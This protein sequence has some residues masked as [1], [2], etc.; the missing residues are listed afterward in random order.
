[1]GS[2]YRRIKQCSHEINYNSENLKAS[3]AHALSDDVWA[4][5][6]WWDIAE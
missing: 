2:Q 6:V 1:M 4:Q 5:P 3:N